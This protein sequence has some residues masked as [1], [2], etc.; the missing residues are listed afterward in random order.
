MRQ[1]SAEILQR[2]SGIR[3]GP[4][5]FPSPSEYLPLQEF[6]S[7]LERLNV[8]YRICKT[9]CKRKPWTMLISPEGSVSMNKTPP[10]CRGALPRMLFLGCWWYNDLAIWLLMASP[11]TEKNSLLTTFWAPKQTALAAINTALDSYQPLHSQASSMEEGRG[12]LMG[13]IPAPPG[14]VEKEG[15][16]SWGNGEASGDKLATVQRRTRSWDVLC[17]TS[18]PERVWF[19]PVL[20]VFAPG[21]PTPWCLTA[22]QIIYLSLSPRGFF[23]FFFSF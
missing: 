10:Y 8:A 12:V 11:M 7:I 6:L 21:G 4:P 3:K 13:M 5:L 9:N 17:T 18:L 22:C 2:H 1:G 23:S 19:H 16:S 15:T 14:W 20:Q